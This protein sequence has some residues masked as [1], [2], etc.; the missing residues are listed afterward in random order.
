LAVSYHSSGRHVGKLTIGKFCP[1]F[2]TAPFEVLLVY[3]PNWNTYT[4]LQQVKAHMGLG[5]SGGVKYFLFL[6]NELI[7]AFIFLCPYGT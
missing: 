2:N 7:I 4:R 5:A 1:L 3:A 6:F